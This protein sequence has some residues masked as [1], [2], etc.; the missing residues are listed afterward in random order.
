MLN[1]KIVEGLCGDP[2]YVV[3]DEL[4]F[5][6]GDHRTAYIDPESAERYA[7]DFNRGTSQPGGSVSKPAPQVSRYPTTR[8]RLKPPAT[9]L[10]VMEAAT[11]RPRLLPRLA[12]LIQE[13]RLFLLSQAPDVPLPLVGSRSR[14]SP[15]RQTL[16]ARSSRLSIM[17][18]L[19]RLPHRAMGSHLTAQP[20]AKRAL[21]TQT[22]PQSTPSPQLS[23]LLRPLKLGPC[24]GYGRLDSYSI[25]RP[26]NR[27]WSTG[28]QC[29]AIGRGYRRKW[30]QRKYPA[31]WERWKLRI[32]PNLAGPERGIRGFFCFHRRVYASWQFFGH[33]CCQWRKHR[34]VVGGTQTIPFA[35]LQTSGSVSQ[36]V[37][38]LNGHTLATTELSN[39]DAVIQGTTLPQGS[40]TTI[41]GVL[42]GNGASGLALGSTQTVPF[43]ATPSAT[44]APGLQAAVTL[45]SHTITASELPGG[46]SMVVHGTTLTQG[47]PAATIDGTV[48]RD[49]PNGLVIGGT[50]TVPLSY[51]SATGT[52]VGIQPAAATSAETS[53][54]SDFSQGHR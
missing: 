23:P 12:Q 6:S 26:N 32:V 3:Y 53:G 18:G 1:G 30:K 35:V 22:A 4:Y 7:R 45:G 20:P 52:S 49:G 2:G 28:C 40:A 54:A 46:S 34:L 50:R 5:S 14:V 21:L 51:P 38:T 15:A 47:G 37:V 8:L 19:L 29:R 27:P 11:V 9:H 24:S 43:S 44:G 48:V 36:A 10:L 41:D 42:V 39:G 25:S 13:M 33:F 16:A 17:A 31:G